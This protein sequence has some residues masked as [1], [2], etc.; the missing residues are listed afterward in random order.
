MRTDDERERDPD[1][2]PPEPYNSWK[3]WERTKSS[4][5][6]QDMRKYARSM[7]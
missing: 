1:R 3:E 2:D 6:D 5:D 7:V 4:E